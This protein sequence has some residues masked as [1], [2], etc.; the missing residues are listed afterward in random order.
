M[1]GGITTDIF[2][3]GEICTRVM[4]W[5]DKI[6]TMGILK[7]GPAIRRTG[8]MINYRNYSSIVIDFFTWF[9][10]CI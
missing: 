6:F 9:E 3:T 8:Q 7:S 4:G 5:L 2:H 1:N 10:L